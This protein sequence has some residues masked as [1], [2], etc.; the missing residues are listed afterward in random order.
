MS[1]HSITTLE[2]SG[3]NDTIDQEV[4]LSVSPE[5]SAVLAVTPCSPPSLE[6][7]ETIETTEG[8][9]STDDIQ[10]HVSNES[11]NSEPKKGDPN[12][13]VT[14]REEQRVLRRQKIRWTED[15]RRCLFERHLLV[16]LLPQIYLQLSA[17]KLIT[18]L[19]ATAD[20][21]DNFEHMITESLPLLSANGVLLLGRP[22]G[23]G[24]FGQ[25]VSAVVESEEVS[26][27]VSKTVCT[28]VAIKFC[29]S[30]E[31][32]REIQ[33][34]LY[35]SHRNVVS[36]YDT[37]PLNDCAFVV[38]ELPETDLLSY[39][40][41]N[42]ET[43][44]YQQM[45]TICKDIVRGVKHIHDMEFTHWDLKLQ[46]ILLVRDLGVGN[47]VAKVGNFGR[48]RSSRRTTSGEP[49]EGYERYGT[50][51]YSS[52]DTLYDNP[53]VVDTEKCDVWAVGLI[54]YSCLYLQ[55][56]FPAFKDSENKES[57]ERRRQL[58]TEESEDIYEKPF[59]ER[60]RRSVD[61]TVVNQLLRRLLAANPS[62]RSELSSLI[63]DQWFTTT[64]KPIFGR[65]MPPESK[66]E[67]FSESIDRLIDE[68]KTTTKRNLVDFWELIIRSRF[69]VFS[70]RVV[71]MDRLLAIDNRRVEMCVWAKTDAEEDND[72]LIIFRP[73]PEDE[74][75]DEVTCGPMSASQLQTI[76]SHF[77]QSLADMKRYRRVY[78]GDE[79]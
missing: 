27:G 73:H 38:M 33:T 12:E 2:N 23:F 55:S 46:N 62:D 50:P 77:S 47:C 69:Q 3:L 35:L 60:F 5:S 42:D 57:I 24:H 76:Q 66:W 71:R 26:K 11:L 4:F 78:R 52:L 37:Q 61:Q 17:H 53:V 64:H 1:D 70:K 19:K 56:P 59:P 18:R 10:T 21:D 75:E 49:I 45:H 7:I 22:L 13:V 67:S 63:T 58:L 41:A 74:T 54:L 32:R 34:A 20:F 43:V 72:C 68:L 44:F 48:I 16:P 15:P 36:V 31:A 14:T 9:A 8:I 79:D 40:M 25:V 29:R 6:A 28:S 39:L 51:D 30:S 65:Q